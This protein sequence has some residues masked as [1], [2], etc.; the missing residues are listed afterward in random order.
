VRDAQCPQHRKVVRGGVCLPGDALGHDDEHRQ[1]HDDREQHERQRLQ[2]RFPLGTDRLEVGVFPGLDLRMVA[3]D[4][5][6]L[7]FEG[8]QACRAA[9][10]ME[11]ES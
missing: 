3:G 1:R 7:G 5:F 2:G 11:R 10:E 8:R 6:H 9:L 4:A